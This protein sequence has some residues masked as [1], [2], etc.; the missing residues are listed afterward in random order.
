M[1]RGE[2]KARGE[3]LSPTAVLVVLRVF[4]LIV[5]VL[6]SKYSFS[7]SSCLVWNVAN[8]VHGTEIVECAVILVLVVQTSNKHINTHTGQHKVFKVIWLFY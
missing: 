4:F 3:D 7:L 1:A 5:H 2:T 8:C 6:P